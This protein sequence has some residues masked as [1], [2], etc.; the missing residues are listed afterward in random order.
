M[1][2][3]IIRHAVRLGFLVPRQPRLNHKEV[4]VEHLKTP[5]VHNARQLRGHATP[6]PVDIHP[7]IDDPAAHQTSE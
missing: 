2:L 7:D 4:H 1:A 3:G 6:R 5:E